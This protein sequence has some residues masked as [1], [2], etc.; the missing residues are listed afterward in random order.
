MSMRIAETVVTFTRSFSLTGTDAV[1]PPGTYEVVTE[2]EQIPGLSFVVFRRLATTLHV[3]ASPAPGQRRKA[4]AV[5]P[6]EL[7]AALAA[8]AAATG[9]S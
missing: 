7:A 8:D 1:Q 3:P 6:T 4:I 9:T 2:E 5:D